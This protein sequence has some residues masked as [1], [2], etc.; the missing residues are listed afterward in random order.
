MTAINRRTLL[1]CGLAGGAALALPGFADEESPALFSACDDQNGQHWLSGWSLSGKQRFKLP[2]PWRGH[3]VSL[4][5]DGRHILFFARRPG[6]QIAVIDR[7]DGTLKKLIDS[8]NGRHFFGHGAFSKDGRWLFT[9]ENNYVD[10]TGTIGVYRT[11][12]FKRVEEFPSGNIGPHQIEILS[13]GKTLV[14]ANGGILTHPDTPREALNLDTMSSSLTYLDTQTGQI[15]EQ[16]L[17]QNPQMS[18]RHLAVSEDDTVVMGVQYQGDRSDI[19]PLVLT[20]KDETT[21]QS[22]QSDDLHWLRQNQYI[23]S[24]AVDPSATIAITTTP[25]GHGVSVWNLHQ[26]QLLSFISLKDVAGA[27]YHPSSRSFL[28]SNGLGQVMSLDV[29][30][31]TKLQPVFSQHSLRWDNHLAL[32]T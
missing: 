31:P 1:R 7:I 14:V 5:P 2:V 15:L 8:E 17:P 4:T 11:D 24:V 3:D 25:R 32:H 20:H 10:G 18:I 21:L 6:R 13:D 9:S 23:A 28:V 12:D 30:Q 22:L 26:R 29:R 27:V 19:L 16:F